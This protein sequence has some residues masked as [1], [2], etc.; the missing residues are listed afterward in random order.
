MSPP[1]I[2]QDDEEGTE[3]ITFS[4]GGGRAQHMLQEG[5]GGGARPAY[6]DGE[7]EDEGDS[8]NPLLARQ[9]TNQVI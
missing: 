5:A 2:L 1:S 8:A 4:S 7:E 6:A 9:H 3:I